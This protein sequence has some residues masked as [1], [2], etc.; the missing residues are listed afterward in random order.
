MNVNVRLIQVKNPTLKVKLGSLIEKAFERVGKGPGIVGLVLTLIVCSSWEVSPVFAVDPNTG[1]VP[2]HYIIKLRLNENAV[3]VAD[4]MAFTHGLSVGH[5]YRHALNGFSARVPQG[6]LNA[7]R[8]D[9]RVVSIVADRYVSIDKPLCATPPCGGGG[10]G[11]S[12]DP[13]QV[14]PNGILRING[15]L[16][17]VA[18]GDG[19]GTVDIDVAV[20]DTGIYNHK[21]LTVVGGFNCSSGPSD[22]YSDGNGHG[23]HVAGTIAAK[24]N[25][26]GVVGVAPG[27]RLWAVRVLN[28]AGSGTWGSVI[29]GIDFVTANAAIIKVANMSLGGAGSKSSCTDGGMH[30]AIC[31]SVN[32]GV[33][34]VVA[35]GNDASDAANQVP[36]AYDEVVTV[37]ALA[38]FDGEAGG[39]GSPTCR[40][41]EDDTFA[42]FSNYGEDVDI[43]AP[44]VCILSTWNDGGYNTISGT[45]MAA[46]HVTGAAALYK[47]ANPNATPGDIKGVLQSIGSLNWNNFDDPDGVKEKLLDVKD[48]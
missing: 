32:A 45:S 42:N 37:S 34:Y 7:L 24:D 1:P 47:A 38:D 12:N 41:D 5:I 33:T 31:N 18:S 3:A 8:S 19:V 2:D 36:A 30:E 29:C 17:S 39:F 46:P 35:A 27:A 15:H 4:E 14:I 44:G 25:S 10:G 23:T 26:F 22:K 6:R 48:F 11:N 20:L 43:I 28:N 9:P 21:D 40:A 16:N 13:P